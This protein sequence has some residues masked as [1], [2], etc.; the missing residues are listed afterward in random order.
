MSEDAIRA[1]RMM[2]QAADDMKQAALNIDGSLAQHR[3]F[4]DDWLNRLDGVLQDR[5]HDFGIE[6]S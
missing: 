1:A 5:I 6:R 3:A 2:Q 4:M